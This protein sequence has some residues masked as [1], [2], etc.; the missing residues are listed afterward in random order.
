MIKVIAIDDEPAGIEVLTRYITAYAELELCA[1]TTDPIKGVEL[2]RRYK[3]HISFVDINMD[4]IDGF[5][6][7]EAVKEITTVVFCSANSYEEASKW[8]PINQDLYLRKIFNQK[9]FE[10]CITTVTG[11]LS[12]PFLGT[13]I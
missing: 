13:K 12:L 8:Y 10:K 4:G 1:T 5:G 9:D 2:I 6:V 7:A 3:P 11:L